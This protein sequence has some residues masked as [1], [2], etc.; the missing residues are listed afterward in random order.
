MPDHNATVKV[1]VPLNPETIVLRIELDGA[2]FPFEPGQYAVLGLPRSAPRLPGSLPDSTE[3]E[4]LPADQLIRRAYSI[5][6]NSKDRQLEFVVTLVRSGALSPRLFA[7]EAGSR[8]HVE[9]R[10]AGTF[11]LG[12]SS[13]N[14]DLLLVATGSAIAPYLSMLKTKVP[15][16]PEHQYVV[17]H[18]AAVSWDLAFRAQLEA[19]AEQSKHFAY[20]PLITAPE[21]DKSWRGLVGAVEHLLK[22][23]EFEDLLGL[24]ITPERFDAYLAGSPEMIEAVT[25]ELQGRGFQ[26]GDPSNPGTNIHVERYW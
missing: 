12:T 5:T 11:T 7:L 19:L 1:V 14:R 13:G 3:V 2:P 24:P 17:I 22:G 23:G 4:H 20:F 21:R 26:G 8:V 6:S 9:P 16:N 25:L 18:A 15:E 10:A